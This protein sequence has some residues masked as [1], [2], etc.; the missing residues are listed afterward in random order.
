MNNHTEAH[1]SGGEFRFTGKHMLL[2]MLAFFGTIVTVN[3]YMAYKASNSWTG[4]IV[5]NG[6]VASQDFN[7]KAEEARRQSARGWVG[8]IAYVD[9]HVT[10]TL[11]DKAGKPVQLTNPVALVGRPAFEGRDHRLALVSMGQGVYRMKDAL[12]TGPWQIIVTADST[13]GAYRLEKRILVKDGQQ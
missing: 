8:D 5:K 6:Y 10:F 9:G 4:L 13:E 2:I 1:E 3:G 7:A 12:E 11:A